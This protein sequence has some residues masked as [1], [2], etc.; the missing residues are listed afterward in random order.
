VKL[1]SLNLLLMAVFLLIPDLGRLANLLVLNRPTLAA[2]LSVPELEIRW[3]KIC[4]IAFQVLF[5]GYF[6]YGTIKEGWEGYKGFVLNRPKAPIYGLYEVE[7]FTPLAPDATRW[8]RV[9]THRTFSTPNTTKPRAA[10]PSTRKVCSA[11]HARTR[12]TWSS[13]AIL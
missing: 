5:V 1:Y 8:R 11:I 7:T 3:I 13:K 2:N 10:S 4:A 6:L 12:N 9:T